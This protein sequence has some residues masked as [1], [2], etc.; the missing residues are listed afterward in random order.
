MQ[1]GKSRTCLIGCTRLSHLGLR[2]P[3]FGDFRL[4]PAAPGELSHVPG[5]VALVEQTACRF[6]AIPQR[7]GKQRLAMLA[8][9]AARDPF[10]APE[11]PHPLRL[12]PWF[13][14]DR[15][16]FRPVLF[17]IFAEKLTLRI[18][19]VRN[20]EAVQIAGA[21]LKHGVA[22]R[23]ERCDHRLEHMHLRVLPARH[24]CRNSLDEAAMRRSQIA[25]EKREQG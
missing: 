21:I 19:P 18:V 8:G 17:K 12:M 15:F 6:V 7:R 20:E 22:R 14:T 1:P 9:R 24:R 5:C 23:V 13:N 25:V 16:N 2:D 10:K 4:R 3:G 11:Q